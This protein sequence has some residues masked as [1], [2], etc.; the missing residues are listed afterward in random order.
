MKYNLFHE[1]VTVRPIARLSKRSH[2]PLGL[3]SSVH[4]DSYERG[5]SDRGQMPTRSDK[6]IKDKLE[7]LDR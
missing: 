3:A 2:S 1:D 5:T 4:V 7:V 6:K